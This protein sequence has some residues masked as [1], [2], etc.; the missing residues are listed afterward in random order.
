VI[1]AARGIWKFSDADML[2]QIRRVIDAENRFWNA[3]PLSYFLVTLAP[4][5]DRS[6]TKMAAHSR[7]PTCSSSRTRTQWTSRR[8][9]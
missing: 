5:D 9:G 2:Q 6:G 7:T 4:F 8:F 3:A 1:F